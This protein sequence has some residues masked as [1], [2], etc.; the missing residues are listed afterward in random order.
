MSKY[1]IAKAA[2]IGLIQAAE[3]KAEPREGL[4][5]TPDRFAKAWEFLTSGYDQDPEQVLKSFEDGSERYDEMV[6]QGAVPVWSMCEHHMLPFWGVAH[7]GYIPNGK[8]VGLSKFSRLVD[9]FARRLQVQE[10]LTAQIADA[11]DEHLKPKGVGV[12]LRCRHGCMESRG[13]QKSGTVTFTSALRGG[14]KTAEARAEFLK[15]VEL[16]D[17]GK[18]L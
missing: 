10:R 11:L 14:L 15:F 4:R 13:I 6:F 2:A 5:E 18:T 9:I 12:V 1:A 3:L 8:I 16:A 17:Q 7:I